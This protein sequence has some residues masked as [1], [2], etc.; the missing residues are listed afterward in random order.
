MLLNLSSPGCFPTRTQQAAGGYQLS[1][2]IDGTLREHSTALHSALADGGQ[3]DRPWVPRQ[4]FFP[5]G[6]FC[7]ILLSMCRGRPRLLLQIHPNVR[8]FSWCRHESLYVTYAHRHPPQL[9]L[10][11]SPVL[12]SRLCK[13]H[14]IW[15]RSSRVRW[16][17][18]QNQSRTIHTMTNSH[19]YCVP[20]MARPAL[21]E[22]NS[23]KPPEAT[24]EQTSSAALVHTYSLAGAQGLAQRLY[25][26]LLHD[27]PVAL[28]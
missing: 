27:T 6:V 3:T 5:Y 1:A 4:R 22:P 9:A 10:P 24:E 19:R 20:K 7:L 13:F 23:C 17:R 21:H 15:S 16:L 12:E 26:S 8:R 18:R 28:P 14:A 2:V 25:L 11:S